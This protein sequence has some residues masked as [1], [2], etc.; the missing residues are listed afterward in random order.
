M[1]LSPHIL[2]LVISPPESLASNAM[3]IRMKYI[4]NVVKPINI[5]HPIYLTT[6]TLCGIRNR[7]TNISKLDNMAENTLNIIDCKG[8]KGT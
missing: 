2:D 8:S 1:K 7:I 5:P 6:K 4:N 3:E